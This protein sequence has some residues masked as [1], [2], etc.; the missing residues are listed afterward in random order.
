MIAFKF[1]GAGA[2]G[3]FTGFRWPVPSSGVPGAWVEASDARADHGVHACI[4]TDLAFWLADELWVVELVGPVRSGHRQ[5]VGSRGRLLKRIDAWDEAE[6]RSFAEACAWRARDRVADALR[7]DGLTVEASR[8]SEI[9]ELSQLAATARALRAREGKPAAFASYLRD[10]A[11]ALLEGD[12]PM[13]A[14]V[15]ARCAVAVA[16][17][18]ERAFSTEREEQ[19][20]LLAARLGLLDG[21]PGDDGGRA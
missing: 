2:V 4:S 14:Y 15:S 20:K 21:A 19:G 3:P 13:S 12:A 11:E 18:E 7:G 16:G 5:I 10:A 17:G 9:A 6:V 8:L 1:L